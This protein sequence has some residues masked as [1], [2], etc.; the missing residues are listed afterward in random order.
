MK[1]LPISASC[2]AALDGQRF[3]EA[4]RRIRAK[5]PGAALPIIALTANA[6]TQ[7][8][9]ACLAAGMDDFLT[10]PVRPELLAATLKKWLGSQP[11][12]PPPHL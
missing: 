9:D 12:P 6:S 10:K 4:T 3:R 5:L 7:D 11:P 8:R 2:S 1:A